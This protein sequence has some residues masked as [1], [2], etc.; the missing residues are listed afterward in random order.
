MSEPQPAFKLSETAPDHVVFSDGAAAEH[1]DLKALYQLWNQKRGERRMPIRADITPHDMRAYLRRVHLYDVVDGGRDFL[2]R[3]LGTSITIGLGQ[4]P[5]GKLVSQ[6]PDRSQGHRFMLILQHV[7][8]VGKPVRV[9]ADHLIPERLATM[10][11]E[12]LWLPLGS[13]NGVEQVLAASVTA[14]NSY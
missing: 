9:L 1:P 3:V 5:T 4:D 6:H 2:I 12:A 11:V 10:Q 7:V 8:A 13:K 14:L